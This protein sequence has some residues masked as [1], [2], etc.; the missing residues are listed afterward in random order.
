MRRA[1]RKHEWL[2]C[3][4]EVSLTALQKRN[5]PAG[6]FFFC[7]HFTPQSR[8]RLD[9]RSVSGLLLFT[10]TP[11]SI[12]K[13]SPGWNKVALLTAVRNSPCS[14][15]F[16]V[17]LHPPQAA[18]NSE[19]RCIAHWAR[20]AR[21]PRTRWRLLVRFTNLYINN[22]GDASRPLIFTIYYAHPPQGGSHIVQAIFHCALAQFHPFARTDFTAGVSP[23]TSPFLPG[24]RS[25]S[26]RPPRCRW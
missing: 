18:L 20:S 4:A 26:R 7:V 3:C 19:P 14:C 15:P 11:Q 16:S 2:I 24:Q 10:S 22:N 21:I 9:G 1:E 12:A 25:G 23:L 13:P 5:H 8:L 17:S 6:G